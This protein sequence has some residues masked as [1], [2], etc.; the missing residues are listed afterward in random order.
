LDTENWTY[1]IIHTKLFS[2]R[3]T[4]SSG[5]HWGSSEAQ[6]PSLEENG[7]P[8]E[9]LTPE[10]RLPIN[11]GLDGFARIDATQYRLGLF[12]ATSNSCH[13]FGP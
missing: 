10:I 3:G 11:K 2:I 12:V 1:E 8:I 13:I 6:I 9:S 4:G 7:K 5:Y